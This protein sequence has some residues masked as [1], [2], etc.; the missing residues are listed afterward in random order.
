[1]E[2]HAWRVAFIIGCLALSIQNA[3]SSSSSFSINK[4]TTYTFGLMLISILSSL[5]CLNWLKDEVSLILRRRHLPPGELGLPIV[6]ETFR[7]FG[8]PTVYAL[9][10]RQ[11]YGDMFTEKTIL[12]NMSVVV[13]NEPGIAWLWNA[14][15]KGQAQGSWPPVIQQLVCRG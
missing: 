6:G 9:E 14:E 12:S 13:G 3:I 11:K 15:R 2:Q 10:K 8:D 7:L 1:M 4:T 5:L